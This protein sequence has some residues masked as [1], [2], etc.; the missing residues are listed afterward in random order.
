MNLRQFVSENFA[1]DLEYHPRRAVV[2]LLLGTVSLAIWYFSPSNAKFTVVP[3]VFGLGSLTLFVKGAFLLRK[4]SEGL[5]MSEQELAALS[6]TAK[7]K[8]LP[9]LP[10]QAAQIL[11]DFGAG[12][13]LLWPLLSLGQDIDSSWVNPPR[14]IVFVVGAGL[15]VIGWCVRKLTAPPSP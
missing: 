4:S 6:E 5:G 2:Y 7:Q 3:L 9:T 15:F 11:Q 8:R 1:A 14:F 10:E 12:S 13:L